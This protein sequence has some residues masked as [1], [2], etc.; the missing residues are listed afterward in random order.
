LQLWVQEILHEYADAGLSFIGSDLRAA[1]EVGLPVV[2]LYAY[3]LGAAKGA[4]GYF[5]TFAKTLKP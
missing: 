3:L 1:E 5:P 2:I 4:V